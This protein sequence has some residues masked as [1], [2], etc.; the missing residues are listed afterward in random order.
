MSDPERAE[1][2]AAALPRVVHDHPAAVLLV[3]T[4]ADLV[5]H[6]NDLAR[7]LAPGVQ[8]P[9]GVEEWSRAAG[10]EVASGVDLGRSDT[11]LS[12]LAAGHPGS[13]RQVSAAL[14]SQATQAR[15][16]LWA[17][18]LPLQGAPAPLRAHA[19]LVLM[20]LRFPD[21]VADV[22][23]VAAAGRA[24]RSVLASGLSIAISDPTAPDDPLVWVS[25][26]FEQLTGYTSAEIVGRN[27]RFLQGPDTESTVVDRLREGLA[28]DRTVSATLLNYRHDGSAFYNHLV[29]SPV[30][31]AAGALTHRVGIQTDVTGQFLASR[32]RDAAQAEVD[33]AQRAQ[34][35]AESADRYGQLLLVMSEALA[36]TVS[37][38]D[39]ATT[40]VQVLAP[41]LGAAGGGLLLADPAH[42]HL[43]LVTT[44]A[45]PADT[46]WP[47]IPWTADVPVAAAVRT[48]QAVFHADAASVLAAHPS[49]PERAAVPAAGASACLPL[50]TG[51]STGQVVGAVF[52]H[53]DEPRQLSLQQR[54]AL[55]ALTRYTAQAVQRATLISERRSAALVLQQSLL[56]QLPEPDHLELRARYVPAA[57]E[58]YVGGDWYDAVVLPDGATA[59]VIGD[60][61]G[62]DMAAAGHMG[63][64]R[65][66]L[67]AFAFDRQ[68]PPS[69]IV[70]R[71]DRALAGLRIDGLATLV[72]A[73]IEQ[74]PQDAAAGL[75]RLRWTNAGHP[76][77]VLLLADGTTRVLQSR[78][79]LLA[80]LLPGTTRTDHTAVLPPASTL[81]LFTDGL[82]EHRGR[83]I[84]EG[85]EDLRRVLSA[86]A[87]ETLEALLDHLVAELVGP[88]PED[89]CA[90]LA[91]RAHPEDRPRPAE[92]GPS[93]LP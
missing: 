81:L 90:I 56:T 84:S 74:D 5:V 36:A 2:Q 88:A 55:E 53:W 71:L 20:P 29:V 19:L 73:R 67:R 92:A 61:T 37:V 66:L 34:A 10:L 57:T 63:Q 41:E 43:E 69:E 59:V 31:D 44:P 33:R 93:H 24:H 12:R 65:G 16:A 40:V 48:R 27:C 49:L 25:P 70:D 91:V 72:L 86:H 6:V 46:A 58:E 32:E 62:H 1:S 13:G 7:Q 78:P 76:P 22:R 75:R 85:V 23:A 35:D 39:V 50:V 42:T 11:P 9:V 52:L 64:L 47:R 83:S 8:L 45:A 28:A 21:A 68:E 4:E 38:E 51:G 60:V 17:I 14:R 82:I 54:S 79:E 77:P 87:G 18:G 26:G 30:F 80:G 3:D 89:D 15:E